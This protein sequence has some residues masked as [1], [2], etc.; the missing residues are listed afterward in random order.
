MKMNEVIGK[1]EEAEYYVKKLVPPPKPTDLPRN[2]CTY[3]PY[4]TECQRVGA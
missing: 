3:C 2:T 1:I 4:K